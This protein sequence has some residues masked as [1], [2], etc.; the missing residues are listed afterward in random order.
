MASIKYDRVF[1]PSLGRIIESKVYDDFVQQN[2]LDRIPDLTAI[3]DLSGDPMKYLTDNPRRAP[4]SQLMT[5]ILYG[6]SGDTGYLSAVLVDHENRISANEY[7][8][9]CLYDVTDDL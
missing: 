5:A 1:A 8:I 4:S 6:I 2:E 7:D 9:T 3:E